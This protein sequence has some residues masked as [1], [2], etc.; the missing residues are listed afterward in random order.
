L[1]LPLPWFSNTA[2]FS[3][4]EVFTLFEEGESD[5]ASDEERLTDAGVDSVEER[6]MMSRFCFGLKPA[7]EKEGSVPDVFLRTERRLESWIEYERRD[8]R[9]GDAAG[10]NLED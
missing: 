8:I 9:E 10:L 6:S 3:L 5:D 2:R 1:A 4:L 7:V